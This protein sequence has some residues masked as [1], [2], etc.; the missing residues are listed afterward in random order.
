VKKEC[1]IHYQKDIDLFNKNV[2][3][4]IDNHALNLK[5]WIK[6]LSELKKDLKSVVIKKLKDI[7]NL[8]K[9]SLKESESDDFDKES[10]KSFRNDVNIKLRTI[11]A[12]TFEFN[13]ILEEVTTYRDLRSRNKFLVW[14]N[15]KDLIKILMKKR[16]Y[17]ALNSVGLKNEH[18]YRYPHEFSGGQR[19]R[20][21]IARAL[22]NN[23]KIII[24]DEPISA[25][26]VSIQAQV[27]NIMKDL[28]EKKGITFLFIAHD[29]SMV[30]YACNR[31]IIMHNGRILEKGDTQEI[32]SNPIHPYTLSLLRSA[33][34]L[35]KIHIDLA[36]GGVETSYG[37]FNL[38]SS[39][40]SFHSV[41]KSKEHFVFGTE[42]QVK[43]WSKKTR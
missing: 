16:V 29:L 37:H 38:P 11:D 24:A 36:S 41:S 30:N 22:I 32:F 20:I 5:N 7:S 21:V 42:E 23:P 31:M 10:I 18:A 40:Y 35:S 39:Y 33:P 14:L 17:E 12:L 8:L 6:E 34:Q 4:E 9:E 27:I 1:K 15:L 28:A 43:L 25:L 13:T 26:D 2:Q 19:Q 3:P